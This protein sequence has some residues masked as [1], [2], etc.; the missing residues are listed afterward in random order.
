MDIKELRN[1]LQNIKGLGT[2]TINHI[3]E[4]FEKKNLLT[5]ETNYCFSWDGKDYSFGLYASEAEALKAAE[6]DRFG[7]EVYIGIATIPKLRWISNEEHILESMQEQLF[8]DC[9]EYANGGLV[10]TT[11]QEVDLGR[12]I[13]DAV[14]AW[15]DKYNIKPKCYSVREIATYDLAEVEEKSTENLLDGLSSEPSGRYCNY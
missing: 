6:A 15:I 8:E 14:Q 11:D 12:M 10:I 13:D 9:G 1:E 5:P 3:V 7:D 4:H 2:I